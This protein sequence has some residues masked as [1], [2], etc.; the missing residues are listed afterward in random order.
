MAVAVAVAVAVGGGG[1][2]G[3]GGGSGASP[4]PPVY[5]MVT[6]SRSGHGATGTIKRSSSRAWPLACRLRAE[7]DGVIRS[8]R[9]WYRP[10]CHRRRHRPRR[11]RRR[12][13]EP[14]A[15]WKQAPFSNDP[16][17]PEDRR[18]TANHVKRCMDSVRKC[19][20]SIFE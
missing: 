11:H 19:A 3:G 10:P 7:T 15:E 18:P 12:R 17:R 16:A 4:P 5:L 2:S 6:P 13:R 14:R 20:G 1:S 8:Q 9:A